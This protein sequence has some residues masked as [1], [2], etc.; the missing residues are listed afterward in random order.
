MKPANLFENIPGVLPDE[1]LEQLAGNERVTIERIVSHGHT[2]P[3]GEWFD[4]ERDEWVM[5]LQGRARLQFE[6]D[7]N[8][9]DMMSGDHITIP[10]HLRH[11]V[12]WTDEEGDTIWLAVHF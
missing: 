12:A 2:T 3:E 8:F 6:R 10:A 7:E 4:Q 5:L 9:V 1:L 11:R